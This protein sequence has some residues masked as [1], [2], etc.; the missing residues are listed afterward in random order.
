MYNLRFFLIYE[1]IFKLFLYLKNKYFIMITCGLDFNKSNPC[2]KMNFN[3]F[4]CR[5]LAG[6]EYIFKNSISLKI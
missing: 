3:S 2:I 6:A 5:R 4:L 1:E